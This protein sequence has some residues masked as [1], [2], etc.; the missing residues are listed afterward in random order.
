VESFIVT[1][2]VTLLMVDSRLKLWSSAACILALFAIFSSN[3]AA[4]GSSV[5]DLV[6]A[7]SIQKTIKIGSSIECFD[8]ANSAPD[9]LDPQSIAPTSIA[10]AE[11]IQPPRLAAFSIEPKEAKR[12][13]SIQSINLTAHIIDDYS[14]LSSGDKANLSASHFQSP[15]GKQSS[16]AIFAPGN[17]TSGS[18]LDGIY[19]SKIILPQ[20][21]ELGVWQLCNLT[22]IDGQGNVRVESKDNMTEL[23]FPVQFLVT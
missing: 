17:L 6:G 9:P 14:G 1:E 2:A 23:G 21:C 4:Y 19:S 8:G 16:D 13:V 22:L 18:K 5:E 7:L 10:L 15:S 20:N 3:A 11:D 12:G